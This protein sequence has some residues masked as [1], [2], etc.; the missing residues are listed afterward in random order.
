M[1]WPTFARRMEN[2]HLKTTTLRSMF[3]QLD[4][5]TNIIMRF[6]LRFKFEAILCSTPKQRLPLESYFVDDHQLMVGTVTRA[7]KKKSISIE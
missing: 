7:T 4:L 5:P 6:F 3:C 1:N 2:R